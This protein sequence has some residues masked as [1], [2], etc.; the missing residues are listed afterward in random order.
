MEGND[1]MKLLRA[2][3][4]AALG[5]GLLAG[6]ASALPTPVA[7]W[8][9]NET[10][11]TV[12]NDASGHGNVGT[13]KNVIKGVPGV[14]G[15]GYGFNGTTSRVIVKNSASLNPGAADIKVTVHVATTTLPASDADLIRKGYQGTVGGDYK[16]E[17]VNVSGVAKARCFFRGATAS[18]QKTVAVA[19]LLNGAYHT[20]ICQKT[21]TSVNMTVDGKVYKHTTTIGSI[22][23]TSSLII[24]AYSSGTTSG[25]WFKGSLDEISIITGA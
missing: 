21:A 14:V 1:R 7:V 20:I 4:L 24:G 18:Y 23:N 16:V 8:G 9:M 10:T 15:T 6:T 25:D 22:S 11:G 2:S 3:L 13:L 5:V 12:M 17:I 19:N